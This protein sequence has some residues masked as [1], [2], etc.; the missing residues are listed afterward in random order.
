MGENKNGKV[1]SSV[2]QGTDAFFSCCQLKQ[3]ELH[4]HVYAR[5]T[6]LTSVNL[7]TR[8]AVQPALNEGLCVNKKKELGVYMAIKLRQSWRDQGILVLFPSRSTSIFISY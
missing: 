5:P 1:C 8:P 7:G 2:M 4:L 6:L 3:A